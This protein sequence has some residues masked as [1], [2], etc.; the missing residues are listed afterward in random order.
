MLQFPRADPSPGSGAFWVIPC[1]VIPCWVFSW[2]SSAGRALHPALGAELSRAASSTP[3]RIFGNI[4]PWETWEPLHCPLLRFL[5]AGLTQIPIFCSLLMPSPLGLGGSSPFQSRHSMILLDE[6]KLLVLMS[7][8][9]GGS[10]WFL[11]PWKN[12]KPAFITSP[13]SAYSWFGAFPYYCLLS[14]GQESLECAG[15]PTQPPFPPRTG[16]LQPRNSLSGRA[17]N[18]NSW[19]PGVVFFSLW[20]WTEQSSFFCTQGY[21]SLWFYIENDSR[22]ENP[23]CTCFQRAPA[24]HPGWAIFEGWGVVFVQVAPHETA[25]GPLQDLSWILLEEFNP[26][27]I[28]SYGTA[29]LPLP[30]T[31][32]LEKYARGWEN[33]GMGVT[34]VRKGWCG[35]VQLRGRS[36]MGMAPWEWL[37]GMEGCGGQCPTAHTSMGSAWGGICPLCTLR[38]SLSLQCFPGNAQNVK[39]VRSV[40]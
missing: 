16:N 27:G 30:A 1:W 17:G 20:A 15:I 6:P 14:W 23:L 24:E 33:L 3:M 9:R 21:L 4:A 36:S 26:S 35:S 8:S 40:C 18:S 2:E 10:Q 13:G 19:L 5:S 28:V 25:P 34:G 39:E 22:K 12:V 29:R 32:I 31:N 37:H 7:N 11:F 38:S